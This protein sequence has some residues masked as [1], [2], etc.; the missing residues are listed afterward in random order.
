MTQPTP[1]PACYAVIR[2]YEL[3]R[4]KAYWDADGK[5]WTC[6]WGSTG[7][8]VVEGTAW[9]QAQAD[10]RL[11]ADTARAWSE[12]CALVNV[13]LTQGQV[14][15]LTDF[16]FNEGS[17][18]FKKSTLLYQLNSGSYDAVPAQLQRW[19]FAGGKPNARLK[20]RRAEE[21][22]LWSA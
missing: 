14:D 17:G 20:E 5:V 2:K 3:C 15:A 1:S 10:A 18:R 6:G 19:V 13:P 11:E 7:P 12:M 22:A 16:V 9:T 8:D 4:L 21:I